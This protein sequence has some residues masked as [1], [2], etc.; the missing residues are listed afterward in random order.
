MHCSLLP[1]NIITLLSFNVITQEILGIKSGVPDICNED[2][3]GKEE[4]KP[5]GK[6]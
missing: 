1:N 6:Y 4:G 3:P 2:Y 5:W